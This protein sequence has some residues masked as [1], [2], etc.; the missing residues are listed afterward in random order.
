MKKNNKDIFINKE[1]KPILVI[2]TDDDETIQKMISD[3]NSQDSN[4]Y[5]PLELKDINTI[6]NAEGLTSSLTTTGK[7]KNAHH[8]SLE[9]LVKQYKDVKGISAMLICFSIHETFP[10]MEIKEAIDELYKFFVGEEDIIYSILIKN[11]LETDEVQVNTIIKRSDAK[12][13]FHY[14]SEPKS[15]INNTQ[16][17]Q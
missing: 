4:V 1:T 7:G 9:P 2:D 6:L 8:K 12:N 16:E 3:A 13:I 14:L 17:K 5:I 15:Q 10:V 11:D